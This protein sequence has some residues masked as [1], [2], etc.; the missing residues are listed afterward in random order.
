M[1]AMPFQTP[2][3]LGQLLDRAFRLYQRH[4]GRMLL[5]AA[6]FFVPLG[7]LAALLMGVTM[8]SYFGILLSAVD[9]PAPNESAFLRAS[10]AAL[11]VSLFVGGLG[12]AL[13]ALAFLSVTAQADANASGRELSIGASVRAGFTRF[14]AF[15]GLALLVTLISFGVLMLIYMALLVVGVVFAGII[16]GLAAL[17]DANGI[18]AVGA[19]ILS[20]V[21]FMGFFFVMLLPFAYLTTRWIV[22]PVVILTER[23]GPVSALSRSWR[24]TDGSFWRLF[25]LLVL[26]VILNGVVL[27]LPLTLIQ[28]IAVFLM[29]PQIFGLVNGVLTGLGYLVSILWYPFL[30]LTLVLVYYDLR[31]RTENLDLDVRIRAL[32]AAV[33]PPTLPGA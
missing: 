25:G 30:A 24:L 27:S 10:G 3:G 12:L 31:V 28:F 13:G 2:L 19:I 6:I 20:V 16:A 4:F 9:M 11:A 33:R 18:V 7:I 32:E 5:T 15:V 8:D 21:L 23:C 22:A 1:Q 29:T 26:L 14:W 17:T